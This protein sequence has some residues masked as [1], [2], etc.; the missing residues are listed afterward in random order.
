MPEEQAKGLKN[1]AKKTEQDI[2]AGT[3]NADLFVL[4]NR[5]TISIFDSKFAKFFTK[6]KGEEVLEIGRHSIN[7]N[8]GTSSERLDLA[9]IM[10]S[11]FAAMKARRV[12][13]AVS[14]T[15][16]GHF[17]GYF[18]I[19]SRGQPGT[20]TNVNHRIR[21]DPNFLKSNKITLLKNGDMIIITNPGPP[22]EYLQVECNLIDV[23]KAIT[24]LL[25]YLKSGC[26]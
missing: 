4:E 17:D 10:Y 9:K 7:R 6:V 13:Y 18:A 5:R 8:L 1:L 14:V 15:N 19:L 21:A 20:I 11:A 16:K 12:K 3:G 25:S 26:F 2:I 24:F 22:I 23:D